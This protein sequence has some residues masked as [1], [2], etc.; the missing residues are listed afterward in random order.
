M[1]M[2]GEERCIFMIVPHRLER[3]DEDN[4][5]RLAGRGKAGR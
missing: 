1:A 4:E 2:R 5:E 3:V